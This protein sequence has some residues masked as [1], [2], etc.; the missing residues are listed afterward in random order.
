MTPRLTDEMR[1]AIADHPGR[2]VLVFDEATQQTYVLL[3]VESF[4]KIEPL[5]YDDSPPDV[6]EFLPLAH[7]ALAPD[8]DAPGMDAYDNYDKHHPAP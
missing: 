8:W 7:E 1:Q 2:P 5:L 6:D 4:Q 3:P